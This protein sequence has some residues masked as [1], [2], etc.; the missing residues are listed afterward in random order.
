MESYSVFAHAPVKGCL[1]LRRISLLQFPILSFF[2]FVTVTDG[3]DVHYYL[4]N[5]EQVPQQGQLAQL[6]EHSC[7]IREVLGSILR[8]SD[9]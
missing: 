6:V 1:P 3:L 7:R 9:L 8:F 5:G 2:Q 4:F